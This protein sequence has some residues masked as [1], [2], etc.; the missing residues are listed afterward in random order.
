[1]TPGMHPMYMDGVERLTTI[2]IAGPGLVV[3]DIISE[4]LTIDAEGSDEK[5]CA[6]DQ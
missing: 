4:D 6:E 3:A 5:R 1:M 2:P